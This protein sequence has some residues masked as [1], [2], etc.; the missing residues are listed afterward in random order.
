MSGVDCLFGECNGSKQAQDAPCADA[1]RADWKADHCE[2][3][4]RFRKVT[5]AL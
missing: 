4:W 3:I 2:M 1:E 5:K